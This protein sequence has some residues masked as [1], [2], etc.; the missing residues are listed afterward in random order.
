MAGEHDDLGGQALLVL[1]TMLLGV[2]VG[3][4]S[5][6]AGAHHHLKRS[7]SRPRREL[8]D[9]G[10]RVVTAA[11]F[12]AGCWAIATV[13]RRGGEPRRSWPRTA[14]QER[15]SASSDVVRGRGDGGYWHMCC[16]RCS[17]LGLGAGSCATQGRRDGW[18]RS[19]ATRA[20]FAGGAAHHATCWITRSTPRG[21]WG[22]R[23][24]RPA[25]GVERDDHL[26]P[27]VS[28]ARRPGG[29]GALV[30]G[31]IRGVAGRLRGLP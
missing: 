30:Y 27:G 29:P 22:W 24:S 31:G 2:H 4:P 16:G 12:G 18:P 21:C 25:E 26:R 14:C 17:G 3:N 23:C 11:A 6:Y 8:V 5:E 15:R 19:R 28:R 20:G 1:V 13:V 10:R 7:W 9:R